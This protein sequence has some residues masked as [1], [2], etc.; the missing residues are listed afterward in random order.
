L[1]QLETLMEWRQWPDGW[2]FTG[3]AGINIPARIRRPNTQL[4]PPNFDPNT[5]PAMIQ[6]APTRSPP[7]KILIDPE[8]AGKIP[9]PPSI[10]WHR[11]RIAHAHRV[12]SKLI[13][14]P[15]YASLIREFKAAIDES[16]EHIAN[17]TEN[18]CEDF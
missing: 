2:S 15:A 14:N 3:T 10:E 8:T 13:H 1:N 18:N 5:M 7:C 17:T 12:V 11:A 6:A 9:K 4:F 16:L